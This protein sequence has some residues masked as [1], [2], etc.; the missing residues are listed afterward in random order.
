MIVYNYI[1][2]NIDNIKAEIRMGLIPAS[3][4]R[5]WQMYSRYDYYRR[6]GNNTSIS[7]SLAANDCNISSE[8]WAYQ[9]KN[10]MENEV[11]DRK[12]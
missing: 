6:L 3:I 8:S 7:I 1:S 9:I 4:L 5:H 11:P 2:E 12:L 10:K